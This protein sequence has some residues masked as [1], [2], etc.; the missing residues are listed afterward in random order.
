MGDNNSSSQKEKDVP[1]FTGFYLKNRISELPSRRRILY[2]ILSLAFVVVLAIVSYILNLDQLRL[3]SLLVYATLF[4]FLSIMPWASNLL[5]SAREKLVK[6]ALPKNR[7]TVENLLNRA[8]HRIFNPRGQLVLGVVVA[9]VLLPVGFVFKLWQY[10]FTTSGIILG[11]CS[12]V[13]LWLF[14]TTMFAVREI[15]D[16]GIGKICKVSV[17][18]SDRMG[19]Y[20]FMARLLVAFSFIIII[21]GGFA[22][23][24]IGVLVIEVNHALPL[25]IFSFGFILS[26]ALTGYFYMSYKLHQAFI[27]AKQGLKNKISSVFSKMEEEVSSVTKEIDEVK[28]S[29]TLLEKVNPLSQS[30]IA[31]KLFLDEARNMR[32]WPFNKPIVL[33]MFGGLL[34]LFLDAIY[35]IIISQLMTILTP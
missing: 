33:K 24:I 2:P 6:R 4:S 1:E 18:D 13:V 26:I 9:I 7:K 34:A 11:F 32:E 17:T 15:A 25:S 35:P 5:I 19:G 3:S 12:G 20:N 10:Y 8:S 30:F 16:D 23:A 28:M 14:F 29:E 27:D 22:I 21:F 31:L